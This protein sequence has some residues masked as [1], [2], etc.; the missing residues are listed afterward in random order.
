M[1]K[2]SDLGNRVVYYPVFPESVGKKMLAN[3]HIALPPKITAFADICV[4]TG[5]DAAVHVDNQSLR[6]LIAFSRLFMMVPNRSHAPMPYGFN[7]L[8]AQLYQ[9]PEMGVAPETVRMI[10]EILGD[11]INA[12]GQERYIYCDNLQEFIDYLRNR[13]KLLVFKNSE[14]TS[15]RRMMQEYYPDDKIYF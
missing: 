5:S 13:Y 1:L 11:F 9:V 15:L 7:N 14:F 2:V 4:K 3:W 8:Y 10:N 12:S 6:G